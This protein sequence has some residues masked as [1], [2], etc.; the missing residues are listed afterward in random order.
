MSADDSQ[1]ERTFADLA[2]SYLKGKAPEVFKNLI[3][4]QLLKVNDDQT[5]AVGTFGSTVEGIDDQIILIPVFFLNGEIKSNGILL[6]KNDLFLPLESY[7][8][9][10]IAQNKKAILGTSTDTDNT[11]LA[12]YNPDLTP[13]SMSPLFYGKNASAY[14]LYDD[15]VSIPVYRSN[16]ETASWFDGL[17]SHSMG[18]LQQGARHTKS[19][20]RLN[21]PDFLNRESED[22]RTALARLMLKSADQAEQIA[23]VYPAE[24]ILRRNT[25]RRGY[26]D[27]F[28]KIPLTTLPKVIAVSTRDILSSPADLGVT[29]KDKESL[30][31]GEIVIIDRRDDKPVV[32]NA[33]T[34]DRYF[35]PPQSGIYDILSRTGGYE[36]CAVFLGASSPSGIRSKSAL[37]IAIRDNS[38]R[39]MTI[40]NIWCCESHEA[41]FGNFIAKA[42]RLLDMKPS[43]LKDGKDGKGENAV[44]FL[45]DSGGATVPLTVDSVSKGPENIHLTVSLASGTA[46]RPSD[47]PGTFQSDPQLDTAKDYRGFPD[48]QFRK[49]VGFQGEYGPFQVVVSPA[50]EETGAIGPFSQESLTLFVPETVRVLK[51]KM[52][53]YDP[54]G[55]SD[56]SAVSTL[57]NTSRIDAKMIATVH[58]GLTPIS[59][60]HIRGDYTVESADKVK[61]AK[62]NDALVGL[63]FD[64]GMGAEDARKMLKQAY[65]SNQST[66]IDFL[67]KGAA[68]ISQP[69]NYIPQGP[70]APAYIDQGSSGNMF[71]L[72]ATVY[73]PEPQMAMVSGMSGDNT[74]ASLYD[75]MAPADPVPS[76]LRN[77]NQAAQLAANSGQKEFFDT[78]IISQ[79][80]S[81]ARAGDLV[82]QYVPDLLLGLD[83]IGRT[84]FLLYSHGDSFKERYGLD[85]LR[86]LENLLKNSQTNDGDL[87]ILLSQKPVR[88]T[89]PGIAGLLPVDENSSVGKL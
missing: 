58:H 61:T 42:P 81:T 9:R 23:A 35:N 66:P 56:D 22:F 21:L 25:D 31:R 32:Y 19:A 80:L 89:E 79:L 20:A 14:R 18:E 47:Q 78:T 53:D 88:S 13:F 85:S 60:R 6:P 41:S 46:G 15:G 48:R 8:I 74:P 84:L 24:T 64:Y 70:S 17:V 3:G 16:P 76:S 27:P 10:F 73:Q 57:D 33:D 55:Y 29:D 86:Q 77:I 39:S 2:F 65:V 52:R 63:V 7:W 83:R 4:F 68:S 69:A 72:P 26:D 62:Y 34:G 11:D 1:F 30:L 87:V 37:V 45:S 71:N 44:V 40:G 50:Q 54:V 28:F 12:P 51:V 43:E 82:Q 59:V 36:P 67:V 49:N 5:R 38:A 75:P